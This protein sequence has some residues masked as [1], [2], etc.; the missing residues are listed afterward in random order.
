M[1]VVTEL[2]HTNRAAERRAQGILVAESSNAGTAA[3]RT[4]RRVQSAM[5]MAA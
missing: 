1:P 5:D 4:E 2:A 3:Q